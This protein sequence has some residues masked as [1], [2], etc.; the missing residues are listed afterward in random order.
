[1]VSTTPRPLYPGKDPVPIVQEAGWAPG[2]VWTFAKNLAPTGIRSPDCQARSQSLYRL[3]YPAHTAENPLQLNVT[4]TVNCSVSFEFLKQVLIKRCL[5]GYSW[6]WRSFGGT[7]YLH[8]QGSK[9][10]KNPK[11]NT[12]STAVVDKREIWPPNLKRS[13]HVFCTWVSRS[14]TWNILCEVLEATSICVVAGDN[15][16]LFRL[17]LVYTEYDLHN[18]KSD[19]SSC[20]SGR[21]RRKNCGPL[22]FTN[23]LHNDTAPHLLSLNL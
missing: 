13:P 7:C 6:N 18:R 12:V 19:R 21:W 17:F 20:N 14:S 1:V 5:L 3:R 10:S 4:R 16:A 2:P 22:K 9:K 8:C 23:F 15:L 11:L